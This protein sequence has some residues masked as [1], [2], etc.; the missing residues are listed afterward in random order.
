MT[1]VAVREPARQWQCG[2]ACGDAADQADDR[3]D[4]TEHQ[5]A[6]DHDRA[7]VALVTAGGRDEREV[8]SLT[9][10]AYRERRAGQEH[11]LEHR[12]PDRDAGDPDLA[13]ARRKCGWVGDRQAGWWSR[14]TTNRDWTPTP[15]RVESAAPSAR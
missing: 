1:W 5:P 4:D 3:A 7:D 13:G 12:E 6:G 14:S 2:V 9:A 15:I 8:A 11:D 10:R